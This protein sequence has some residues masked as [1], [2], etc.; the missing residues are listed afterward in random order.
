MNPPLVTGPVIVLGAGGHAVV[1][2]ETLRAMGAVIEGA[3][4]PAKT[5]GEVR[6]VPVIGGDGALDAYGAGGVTLANGIGSIGDSAARRSAFERFKELGFR[7]ATLVHPAAV[8]TASDVLFGE[9]AQIMA[10]SVVQTGAR[11][12]PNAI[13]NTGAIVDHDCG[14]G[15]HAHIAP[16][17]VLCGNVTV[18]EGA[19]IGA[20]ATLIQGVS[21]GAE[22]FVAAGALVACDVAPGA[23]VLGVPAR[24]G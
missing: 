9:G 15:A 13:V 22:S 10:G 23:R 19:H 16:G 18:G 2:V 21:V 11:I 5:G 24:E 4:D 7:F 12:G 6:G 14:I 20:G 1:V 17:A 3:V 8:I